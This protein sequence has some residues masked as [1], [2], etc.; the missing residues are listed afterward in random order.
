MKLLI[1]A[2]F[3][4][5]GVA[6]A[7]CGRGAKAEDKV[8]VAP[9]VAKR[10]VVTADS[11]PVKVNIT[12]GFAKVEIRKTPMLPVTVEFDPGEADLLSAVI[13]GVKD[14]ANIRFNQIIM[15]DGDSDGP[16]G[17][18]LQY[19]LTRRGVY[20][21][22]IGESLMEGQPWGGVFT[23]EL[24]LSRNVPY[25]VGRN[26]FVKNTFTDT[27]LRNSTI[28]ARE[29][30]DRVFGR[31]AVMGSLPTPIDF[32]KQYVIAVVEPMTEEA[33]YLDVVSLIETGD[34]IVMT[35]SRKTGE[36][37]SYF[38]RPYLMVIVDKEYSGR[39]T[40]EERP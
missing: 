25:T 33:V 20:K 17:R 11:L 24:R 21:L 16:F 35:Y 7:S 1:I 4:A 12:D 31:A 6:A 10:E 29:E 19:D 15:P 30:F 39:V 8:S 13:T 23:L 22:S 5:I 36:K 32:A 37:R 38:T 27:T 26:Y 2:A 14:T 9:G 18:S 34:D 28:T 3:A 40:V